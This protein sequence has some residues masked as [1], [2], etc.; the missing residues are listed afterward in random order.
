MAAPAKTNAS[1]MI[2][3]GI[4]GLKEV[5]TDSNDAIRKIDA[6]ID[7]LTLLLGQLNEKFDAA[8]LQS[9]TSRGGKKATT[10]G[11]ETAKKTDFKPFAAWFSEVYKSNFERISELVTP[12]IVDDITETLLKRPEHKQKK[13]GSPALAPLI[14]RDIQTKYLSKG[15]NYNAELYDSLLALYNE[16]KKAYDE[17]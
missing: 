10:S 11:T 13:A 7:A 16:D 4:A 14:A 8:K 15:K 5:S 2:L 1:D 3:A 6:K 12:D 9:A 17:Q